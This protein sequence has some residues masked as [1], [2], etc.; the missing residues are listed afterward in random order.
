MSSLTAQDSY[1]ELEKSD[2]EDF[3]ISYALKP[4]K[5]HPLEPLF[6]SLADSNNNKK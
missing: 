3:T 4:A 1:L 2:Y 5:T 6:L